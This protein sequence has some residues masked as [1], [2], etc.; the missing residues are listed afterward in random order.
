MSQTLS[1][2]NELKRRNVLRVGAAYVVGAWLL[3]QVVET[4]FPLFGFD[5]APARIVVIV[6]AIAFVPVLILAWAF[7][8][9]PEG[10][11]KE[12]EV[13]R[14][15]SI[16]PNT[17]KKLDRVIMV[18]LALALGYFAFDKFVL[19]PQR[20]AEQLAVLEEQK[21][22]EV[23]HAR[24]A[25]RTEAMVESYGE[26][27]IAVLAFQDMSQDK[28]Q[29]YLSDGIAEELLNLLAKVPELRVISRSS[30][31]SYKGKSIKLAQ[32]AEE[33]NVAHIL[34]GS[35]RKA[36]NQVRITAQLIEARSDTHL[37]SQTYD[38]TL[39]DIFA[40]QD[41][42]AAMVVEQLKITLFGATPTVQE[43]NPEAYSL[44]LQARHLGRR[45]TTMGI[46]QSIALYEQA[47]ALDPGYAAAWDGL[48]ASYSNQA[49]KGIRP[50]DEGYALA[51]ETA[52][53]ALSIDP[54]YALAHDL[55]G[56]IA[57]VYDNDLSAAARHYERAL[58]LEPANPHILGNAAS[59]LKS[60]GRLDQAIA[61][62]EYVSARD[63]VDPI[64]HAKLGRS[65]FYAGR[66]AE[67]ITSYQ[68]VLR[69]SPGY[70]GAHYRIGTALLFKGELEAALATMQVEE[71]EGYRL[72]GLI[73]AHNAL[74]QAQASDEV[75]AELIDK[76]ERDAAF[77]IAYVLAYRNEADRAFAW[78]DKAVEYGDSGMAEIVGKPE[79]RNIQNDPRW[80][81]FLESIGKLPAQLDEIKFEVTVPQ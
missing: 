3:I 14:T 70:I 68:T 7:E 21:T 73:M 10:L 19:T 58:A 38:R 79:F 13:D 67:T 28:D 50:V 2:F 43:T 57:M 45:Q 74:G 64:G 41:E 78:L 47:L 24:Q 65:Y 56:W 11:K 36:G 80:P 20:D 77:N 62:N 49:S 33:L 4:I 40:I 34:E 48:A 32:V 29:E 12:S 18:V 51:R 60:L 76:Y 72:I 35:V 59:L 25:G 69:L 42:I 30:A 37:W 46:E 44:F 5:E 6:L 27:S 81:T 66:W 1:F 63:P 31:F 54:D 39:D 15:Q 23:E 52:D 55:L 8:L 61:L 71:F 17:G 9:T 16:A 26:K 22:T 53:K 75:L